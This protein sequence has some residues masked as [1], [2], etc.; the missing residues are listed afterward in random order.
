MSGDDAEQSGE[1]VCTCSCSGCTTVF[2]ADEVGDLAQKV[3][4]H[5]N[6][7]HS[8]D[9]RHQYDVIETQE[10]GGHH[11]RDNVYQVRKREVRVTAYDVLAVGR[12]QPIDEAFA[13]P[14]D[15]GCC[16]D[17]WRFTRTREVDAVELESS[18]AW[19]CEWRCEYCH[20]IEGDP[21]R[22]DYDQERERSHRLTDFEEG[23]A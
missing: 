19:G 5:W 23:S 10:V 20:D 6:R 22:P 15:P 18:G 11:V 7:S 1:R 16:T 3:A 4:R 14:D 12:S 21:E 13:T 2:K 8:Q 17:C 9:L